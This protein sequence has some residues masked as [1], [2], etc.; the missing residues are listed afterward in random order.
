MQSFKKVYSVIMKL[1]R[2]LSSTF[3][4]TTYI[5]LFCDAFPLFHRHFYCDSFTREEDYIQNLLCTHRTFGNYWAFAVF[6]GPDLIA[7]LS[8]GLKIIDHASSP[9]ETLANCFLSYFGN[10]GSSFL[11]TLTRCL[12]CSSANR[13]GTHLAE[14]FL[15]FKCFFKIRRSVDN[16]MPTF[17]QYYKL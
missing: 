13:C 2:F 16:D 15:T 4:Q 9:V 14:I 10:I 11:A 3:S 8:D 1:N 7:N 12:F 5:V 6:R 17:V